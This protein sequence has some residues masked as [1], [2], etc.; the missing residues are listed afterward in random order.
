MLNGRKPTKKI[1][2]SN[3]HARYDY[4]SSALR[5]HPG[6]I[7]VTC[8]QTFSGEELRK[9]LIA[10]AIEEDLDY[11]YI[12]RQYDSGT[13]LIYKIYVID[14]R[15]ELVRG[16]TISDDANLKPF[17]RILG[18]SNKEQILS[19]G[20]IQATLI[21]PDALLFEEMDV[22]RMPNIEFKKPYFVPKPK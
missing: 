15:E 11:A 16:A 6:N 8:N 12:V 10:A 2:Q 21:L 18:A 1:G 3:G 13:N 4:N 19:N 22:T 20:H 5:I 14:G 9:R 17:K 7:L